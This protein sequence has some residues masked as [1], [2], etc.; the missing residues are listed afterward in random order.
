MSLI[1]T[2][3]NTH[4]TKHFTLDDHQEYDFVRLFANADVVYKQSSTRSASIQGD[5]AVISH[6]GIDVKN[7]TLFIAGKSDKKAK[8]PPKI[9]IYGPAFQKL[10][11]EGVG[12]FHCQDVVLKDV[13][14]HLKG[15]GSIYLDGSANSAILRL[16]GNGLINTK[17][18]L[19]KNIKTHIAGSGAIMCNADTSAASIINGA[20]EIQ[21]FGS[22]EKESSKVE[23]AG[24]VAVI[25]D[26]GSLPQAFSNPLS[27]QKFSSHYP[28]LANTDE[29]PNSSHQ[30]QLMSMENMLKIM[31]ATGGKNTDRF[32]VSTK[33]SLINTL[34]GIVLLT[35]LTL[36][37]IFG[38]DYGSFDNT[39][40]TSIFRLL[41]IVGFGVILSL[42]ILKMFYVSSFKGYFILSSKDSLSLL[43]LGLL[44]LTLDTILSVKY[45][46]VFGAINNIVSEIPLLIKGDEYAPAMVLLIALILTYFL[47]REHLLKPVLNIK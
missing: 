41:P 20:G 28:V 44:T 45:E 34:V 38:Y 37:S 31:T 47:I 5:P 26:P 22:P 46:A 23:G 14:V 7:R 13:F 24:V 39:Q 12:T 29:N 1:P 36:I 3:S 8:N 42:F 27:I 9:I 17:D 33:S 40:S 10:E 25:S 16:T 35:G 15:S 4:E 43:L 11:V 18:F 30:N 21:V 19:T 32:N 2:T 6:Y